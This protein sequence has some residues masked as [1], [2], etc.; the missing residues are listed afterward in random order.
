MSFLQRRIINETSPPRVSGRPEQQ[1]TFFLME[2]SD[3]L[4]PGAAPRVVGL[5]CARGAQ[6][7]SWRPS[8]CCM[9]PVKRR[10]DPTA[11]DLCTDRP[12]SNSI[13]RNASSARHQWKLPR[14]EGESSISL[15]L[16]G[17]PIQGL[18]RGI[19]PRGDLE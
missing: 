1:S 9:E 14:L 7:A 4:Y 18:Y 16:L 5:C 6:T 2:R 17:S 8:V 10:I 15:P 11:L 19:P 13:S 3:L 12:T